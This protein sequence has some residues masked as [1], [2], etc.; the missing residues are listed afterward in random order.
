MKNR[1]IKTALI[2]ILVCL[3]V[4]T[5]LFFLA[6]SGIIGKKYHNISNEFLGRLINAKHNFDEAVT[7]EFIPH[8]DGCVGN[9]KTEGDIVEKFGMLS[10]RQPDTGCAGSCKKE[11]KFRLRELKL[12]K[13]KN[14]YSA[15]SIILKNP[16]MPDEYDQLMAIVY[17]TIEKDGIT[18]FNTYDLMT[19]KGYKIL[20]KV[21]YHDFLRDE[22]GRYTEAEYGCKI[23]WNAT[24]G[25]E[26]T[27]DQPI[28]KARMF[29]TKE[30]ENEGTFI[31]LW[32]NGNDS[33]FIKEENNLGFKNP[34]KI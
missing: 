17:G 2:T 20:S 31:E 27:N 11:T 18:D 16:K 19:V 14:Q 21:P 22:K 29:D 6:W 1:Y 32:Y 3:L 23:R 30:G 15:D 13:D 34:C 28:I 9:C 10:I 25:W 24:F 26:Y 12:N 8:R 7:P 5:G 4:I 33:E